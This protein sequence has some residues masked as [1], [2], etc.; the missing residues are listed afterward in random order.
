MD[1]GPPDLAALVSVHPKFADLIL[2]G[3]KR[4][5]FRKRRFAESVSHVVIYAT[6]PVQKILGFFEVSA[7]RED[8]PG[9]LWRRYKARG[10]ISRAVFSKYF[11]GHPLGVAIEVG[12]VFTL[13]RPVPLSGVSASSTAPQSFCYL[14]GRVVSK[15]LRQTN[16]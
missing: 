3:R 5:E 13:S 4:V 11:G 8:T 1:P 9:R 6:S 10:G 7:V 14:R 16:R 12:R 15:L 2:T